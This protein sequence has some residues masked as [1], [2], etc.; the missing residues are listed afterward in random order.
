MTPGG[1]FSRLVATLGG[2]A[3]LRRYR[4]ARQPELHQIS[5][6]PARK[7]DAVRESEEETRRE[8]VPPP[9]IDETSDPRSELVVALLLIAAA[10]AFAGFVVFYVVDE[11]TQ[12]L[13]LCLGLGLV[14]AGTAAA[15]AG[16]RVVIQEK[17]TDEYKDYGDREEQIEVEDHLVEA[18]VG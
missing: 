2:L 4:E 7:F 8:Y 5:G 1:L 9:E 11:D 12:L 18:K 15:L 16:K 13:G 10:V 14:L 17:T 6:L 3:G